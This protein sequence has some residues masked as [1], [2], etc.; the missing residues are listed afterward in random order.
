MVCD[1]GGRRFIFFSLDGKYLRQVSAARVGGLIA[2][3]KIDSKG[4]FIVRTLTSPPGHAL[5]K[6]GSKGEPSMTFFRKL[7]RQSP[8]GGIRVMK[9]FLS[10]TLTPNDNIVWG[11][12]DKYELYV[13]NPEGKEIIRI[14]NDPKP[15]KITEEYLER[16]TNRY[17]RLRSLGVDR[18][19][20]FPKHF[21]PF[22]AISIDE[23]GRIFV[24]MYEI[25]KDGKCYYDVFDREGRYIARVPL[26]L[27]PKVWKRNKMYAIHEDDEGYRIVKRYKVTWKY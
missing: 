10:F 3:A 4:N 8:E 21:P 7:D 1:E 22:G 16:L 2:G 11:Y 15:V 12:N 25:T 27:Y 14:V 26:E 20:I 19:P 9:Y 24:G 18:K 17:L 23:E 5:E 13:L 6:L